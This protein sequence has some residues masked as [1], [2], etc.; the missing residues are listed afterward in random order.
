[1]SSFSHQYYLL[2]PGLPSPDT[3]LVTSLTSSNT[4]KVSQSYRKQ[5]IFLTFKFKAHQRLILNP[6]QV[7]LL[8]DLF[9]TNIR[10]SEPPATLW[11]HGLPSSTLSAWSAL[12][13]QTP[14]SIKTFFTVQG[15]VPWPPVGKEP[16]AARISNQYFLFYAFALFILFISFCLLL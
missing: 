15:P 6:F 13:W 2:L 5:F 14:Q 8:R 10:T 9:M 3:N 16:Q 12:C 1:M 11:A 4:N 7:Y